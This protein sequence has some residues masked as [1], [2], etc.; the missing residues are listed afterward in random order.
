[1]L[2]ADTS[3]DD[4]DKVLH[5]LVDMWVKICGFSFASDWIELYKQENKKRRRVFNALRAFKRKL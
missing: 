2:A 1:M 5:M 3:N 4:A